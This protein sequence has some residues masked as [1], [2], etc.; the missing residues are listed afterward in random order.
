MLR[1]AVCNIL[2]YIFLLYV[3]LPENTR[4]ILWIRQDMVIVKIRHGY[5]IFGNGR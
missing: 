5:A 1:M 2:I 3:Q 4:K